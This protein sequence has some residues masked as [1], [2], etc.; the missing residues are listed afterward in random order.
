[1]ENACA[2]VHMFSHD[3]QMIYIDI[4]MT[5]K[6]QFFL[7]PEQISVSANGCISSSATLACEKCAK[8]TPSQNTVV[9]LWWRRVHLHESCSNEMNAMLTV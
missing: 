9:G 7:P 8:I 4:H 3:Y 1:M 2:N 6:N 5:N